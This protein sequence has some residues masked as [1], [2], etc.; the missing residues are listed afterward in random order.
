M[1]LKMTTKQSTNNSYRSLPNGYQIT[2]QN[3][4]R[5]VRNFS[6]QMY[7]GIK[8]DQD[9][10]EILAKKIKTA[11][12]IVIGAGAGLST[13]AGFTYSGKRFK[14]YFFDFAATY[15]I[16]DMYSGGFYPFPK[17]E[18]FWAWWARHIYFNRYVNPPQ[19]VYQKL[20][21]LVKDKDYFVITTNVDHMFQKVVLIRIGYF[22]RKEIM[23]Y[24]RV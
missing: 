18:I 4:L 13:S 1:F 15:G 12:A 3:G 24:S 7:K 21:E 19:P 6:G 10:I 5:V 11:D 16:Q 20:L 17:K 2:I 8:L 23:A 14:E 22:I 9:T